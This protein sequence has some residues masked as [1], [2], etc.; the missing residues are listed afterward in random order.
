MN[1]ST[2]SSLASPIERT[3]AALLLALGFVACD[4]TPAPPPPADATYQVRGRIEYLGEQRVAV[5]HEAIDEFVGADGEQV[6]MRSMT[7]DFVLADGV[8]VTGLEDGDP[9][10]LTFE[11]RWSGGDRLTATA[12]EELPADTEL[13]IA[14]VLPADHPH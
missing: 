10:A 12:L 9:V 6:G 1:A 8:D 2:K 14:D 13:E 3:A 11:V 7:M 5:H 4:E